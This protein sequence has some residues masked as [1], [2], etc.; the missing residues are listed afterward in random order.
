MRSATHGPRLLA[1]EESRKEDERAAASR[2]H[3][4]VEL[5]ET[6][7][8]TLADI[9]EVHQHRADALATAPKE[10]F[11]VGI[12][13]IGAVIVRLVELPAFIPRHLHV[14]QVVRGLARQLTH[15]AEDGTAER[16]VPVQVARSTRPNLRAGTLG[17]A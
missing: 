5:R 2:P 11:G 14:L 8:A 13:R 12:V 10:K 7:R 1:V 6:S 15:L 17:A 4:N 9:V 16:I 3:V